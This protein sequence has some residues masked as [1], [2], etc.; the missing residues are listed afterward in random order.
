MT[1]WAFPG[2]RSLGSLAR[3]DGVPAAIAF[4]I[5]EDGGDSG[6]V[7][8]TGVDPRFRGRGLGRLVKED[9]HHRAAAPRHPA[10]G[11]DNEEHN[12]GIRRLNAELGYQVTYG[13]YRMR[14]LL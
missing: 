7:G 3:V 13:V 6:G 9:V 5:V 1:H 4:A 2:E 11:T 14:Q 10:L 8:Y 12:D